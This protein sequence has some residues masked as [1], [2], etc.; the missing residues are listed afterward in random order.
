MGPKPLV[1][2][3][4][5]RRLGLHLFDRLP[6][7]VRLTEAGQLLHDYA[8]RIFALEQAAETA[9]EELAELRRGR[10]AGGA[11]RT[12]L[13]IGIDYEGD[14]DRARTVALDAARTVDGVLATPEP[15][16]Q[17]ASFDTSTLALELRYWTAPTEAVVNDVR[18]R[19]IRAVKAACEQAGVALP[20]DIVEVDLR[21]GARATLHAMGQRTER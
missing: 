15:V 6:R 17:Y 7:G 12:T 3:S 14:L 19:V 2:S 11:R 16:S 21:T 8:K 5:E 10:L 13:V 1:L 20:A 4:L 18:D 9:L